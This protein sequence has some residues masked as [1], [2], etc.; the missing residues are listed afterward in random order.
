[1]KQHEA[2][3]TLLE[4]LVAL[5]VFGL[6]MAGLSQTTHFAAASWAAATRTTTGTARLA[7]VDRTLRRLIEQALPAGFTGGPDRLV[8]TT[9]LPRGSGNTDELANVALLVAPGGQLELRWIPQPAGI[10]LTPPQAPKTEMLLPG[11]SAI[12]VSYL[13]VQPAGSPA[14]VSKWTGVGLP[15]LV[16]ISL[17]R[18]GGNQWPD[19]VAA[20]IAAGP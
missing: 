20:P 17:Q 6:L 15:L 1:V 19:L 11:V 4:V 9:T 7:A 8:F 16:R 12:R 2:G 5:V 3:F 10:L 18:T 13:S 14:W